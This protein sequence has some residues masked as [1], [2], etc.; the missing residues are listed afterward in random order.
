VVGSELHLLQS[1]MQGWNKPQSHMYEVVQTE[2]LVPV[3]WVTQL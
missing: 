2:S 3:Q 1:P